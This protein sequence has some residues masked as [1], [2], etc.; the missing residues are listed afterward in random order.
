[1]NSI[2]KAE[3]GLLYALDASTLREKSSLKSGDVKVINMADLLNAK[4]TNSY[5]SLESAGSSFFFVSTKV[6]TIKQKKTATILTQGVN[7]SRVSLSGLQTTIKVVHNPEERTVVQRIRLEPS[8]KTK[9]RLESSGPAMKSYS[10]FTTN[11]EGRN[12]AIIKLDSDKK[13]QLN[14]PSKFNE[15]N[16]EIVNIYRKPLYGSLIRI[17]QVEHLRADAS[18][19]QD[20]GLADTKC[21]PR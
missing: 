1:M 15:Y 16:S 10:P 2:C 8:P 9:I 6:P 4:T 18:N 12:S 17:K 5:V 20:Q 11:A 14:K 13:S 3:P 19:C 21:E 7:S